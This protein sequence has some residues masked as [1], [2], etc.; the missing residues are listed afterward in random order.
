MK[1]V[2]IRKARV[3]SLKRIINSLTIEIKELNTQC[4]FDIESLETARNEII[5]FCD[6]LLPNSMDTGT[7]RHAYYG[8]REYHHH[9][10]T[11]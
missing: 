3:K 9:T 5:K 4:E 1:T 10:P 6:K 8:S 7:I 11:M 2:E